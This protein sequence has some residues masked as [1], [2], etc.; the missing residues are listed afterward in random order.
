[1]VHDGY[2]FTLGVSGTPQGDRPATQLL[3]AMMAA[4]PPVKRVAA[5]GDD[6]ALRAAVVADLR[7]AE[8]LLLATPAVADGVPH[9]VAQLLD[10]LA[11]NGT[12]LR[13]K[14]AGLIAVGEAPYTRIALDALQRFCRQVGL[15][16]AAARQYPLIVDA[17]ILADAAAAARQAY[18]VAA[19]RLPV[20]SLAKL[21]G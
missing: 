6:E 14:V 5:L 18:R 2:L 8:L 1:L 9:R 17:G 12:A 15:D 3:L 20:P 4:L 19:E 16:V 21:D 13:G 11:T 7:D 10:A